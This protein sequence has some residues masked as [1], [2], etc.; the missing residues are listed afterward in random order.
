MKWPNTKLAATAIAVIVTI[1]GINCRKQN[2]SLPA[3]SGKAASDD[4]AAKANVRKP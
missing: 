1:S 4:T 3:P 2:T